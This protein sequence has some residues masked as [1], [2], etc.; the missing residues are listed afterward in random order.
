MVQVCEGSKSKNDMLEEAIEQY[1]EIF[2]QAK[3]DFN[4]VVSVSA[5]LPFLTLFVNWICHWV[6]R[7]YRDILKEKINM[8]E[9]VEMVVVAE[10]AVVVAAAAAEEVARVVREAVGEGQLEAGVEGEEEAEAERLHL[11]IRMILKITVCV[12]LK[13]GD[14]RMVKTRPR[15]ST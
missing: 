2:I 14:I 4:K 13:L 7:A 5:I 3:R 1:K 6:V 9:T 12:P 10:E 11:N 15:S 8:V